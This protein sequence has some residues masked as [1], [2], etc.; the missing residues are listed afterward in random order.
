VRAC[1]FL[2]DWDRIVYSTGDN[3][4]N[5]DVRVLA[6]IW[7]YPELNFI[8]VSYTANSRWVYDL[9]V[10]MVQ[11]AHPR[12]LRRQFNVF[13]CALLTFCIMM[14]L[15]YVIS[16]PV[17]T[18]YEDLNNVFY[19]VAVFEWICA[20]ILG[21]SIILYVKRLQQL[22][23]V[24]GRAVIFESIILIFANIAA[25]CFNLWLARG[26]VLTLLYDRDNSEM[27]TFTIILVPYFAFTE[28]LPS[29][30]I[31]ST[32]LKFSKVIT[33]LDNDEVRARQQ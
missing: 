25:G 8:L 26:E 24:Y 4:S 17:D 9:M 3:S 13:V 27:F 12:I 16:L 19:F 33:P 6:L 18:T 21:C 1:F 31:A 11:N 28:F 5:S 29:I 15:F 7:T 32:V 14:Y 10:L 30:V 22:N 23:P 20:A 2:T